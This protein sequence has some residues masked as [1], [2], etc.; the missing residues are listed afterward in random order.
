MTSVTSRGGSS[1]T[2]GGGRGAAIW[3]HEKEAAHI[4]RTKAWLKKTLSDVRDLS[5]HGVE[6]MEVKAALVKA[7]STAF[8]KVVG[9]MHGLGFLL[10][11]VKKV[12]DEQVALRVLEIRKT[13]VHATLLMGVA[14]R[15]ETLKSYEALAKGLEI[16][17]AD[18]VARTRRLEAKARWQKVRMHVYSEK[19][20]EQARVDEAKLHH[21]LR[22]RAELVAQLG[23]ARATDPAELARMLAKRQAELAAATAAADEFVS[24][25]VFEALQ[26]QLKLLEAQVVAANRKH[27]AASK[28][29]ALLSHALSKWAP[30]I[31]GPFA[32]SKIAHRRVSSF[33]AMDNAGAGRDSERW[34]HNQHQANSSTSHTTLRERA[35]RVLQC[36]AHFE[37]AI[38]EARYRD[39]A[40]IAAES[41]ERVLRV[42]ATWAIFKAAKLPPDLVDRLSGTEK[43]SPA[44]MYAEELVRVDPDELETV[45]CVEVAMASGK[46]D[47]VA[48]WMQQRMLFYSPRLA[49]VFEAA[50][51]AGSCAS[52][53]ERCRCPYLEM[54]RNT[55]G[56][57]GTHR[58]GVRIFRLMLREGSPKL[59][60]AFANRHRI[61]SSTLEP[62]LEAYPRSGWEGPLERMKAKEQKRD[63]DQRAIDA[64]R[65]ALDAEREARRLEAE[66]KKAEEERVAAEAREKAAR[67]AE[68][69]RKAEEAAAD[70]AKRLAEVAAAETRRAE[71]AAAETARIAAVEAQIEAEEK[72]LWAVV[73]QMTNDAIVGAEKE[74]EQEYSRIAFEAAA[75]EAG[76]EAIAA[77]AA[78]MDSWQDE[79][80]A[81]MAELQGLIQAKTKAE[82]GQGAAANDDDSPIDVAQAEMQTIETAVGLM[83]SEIAAEIAAEASAGA[84]DGDVYY[85]QEVYGQELLDAAQTSRE[86]G[87]GEA[88]PEFFN[89]FSDDNDEKDVDMSTTSFSA[90]N[91]PARFDSHGSG[92]AVDATALAAAAGAE[93]V[94]DAAAAAAV[95]QLWA[96]YD[97]D[98]NGT[99]DKEEARK[100]LVDVLGTMGLSNEL[101]DDDFETV[102][103]D[104]DTDGS[105]LIEMAEFETFVKQLLGM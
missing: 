9:G 105:G 56:H 81:E 17:L 93:E 70:E 71:A 52:P 66:S 99:L 54:A 49:E 77:V 83:A 23:V 51:S 84:E 100:F 72:A 3:Y 69:K 55:Y 13:H 28:L 44:M 39:A 34:R 47:Q 68:E 98:H 21:H 59:A 57:L 41:P 26:A 38:K 87:G 18:T 104:F 90:P 75:E 43:M 95:Q 25:T 24:C 80:A 14:G 74:L 1:S 32:Q 97:A 31:G 88:A 36:T 11:E 103:A 86:E 7:Y 58:F 60:L 5:H 94:L 29:E 92:A 27:S 8:E 79:I 22:R 89:E 4:Q 78:T 40:V 62:V 85:G 91:T 61:R 35:T 102:F 53:P 33:A 63:E 10:A 42:P 12:L 101:S 45:L 48:F 96:E 15:K 50:C 19:V 16:D 2:R 64:R 30:V 67:E 6:R 76:K 82:G 20:E 65:K 37:A 73:V 46:V